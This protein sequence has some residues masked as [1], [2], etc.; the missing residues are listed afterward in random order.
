MA[1]AYQC[2]E[3][4]KPVECKDADDAVVFVRSCD[5]TEAA[6]LANMEATVYG[7]GKTE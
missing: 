2:A 6:I 1:T 7:E 4:G 3:C 5:H